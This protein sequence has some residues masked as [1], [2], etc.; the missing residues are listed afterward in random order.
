MNVKICGLTTLEDALAAVGLGADMLGFNFY[1]P[2]PRSLK[3]EAARQIIQALRKQGVKAQMIG[4]FVNEKP[5]QVLEV[6]ETCGLDGAQLSGDEPPDDLTQIGPQAF[7]AIRPAD[8]PAALL[9][10]ERY[11]RRGAPPALLLDARVAGQYG[12]TGR[13]ADW[14]LANVLARQYPVLLAG[15]LTPENLPQALQ[16]VQPWGVD[17]ASGV[18]ASPG[19]KDAGKLAAFIQAASQAEKGVVQ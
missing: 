5:R 19:V 15:G 16:Q 18:E 14:K 10:A 7:K 9:L 1:P 3:P 17:V 8:L 4:V 11:A 6:L 12:G 2:S 13:T